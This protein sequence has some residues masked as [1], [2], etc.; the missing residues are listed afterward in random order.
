MAILPGGIAS[1]EAFGSVAVSRYIISDGIASSEAFGSSSLASVLSP[2]GVASGSLG[3]PVVQASGTILQTSI[4]Q[5]GIGSPTIV[6]FLTPSAIG[7]GESIGSPVLVPGVAYLTPYSVSV[8][9][10]FG[11]PGISSQTVGSNLMALRDL[12]SAAHY[13][14]SG[15]ND[16]TIS[17]V[18]EDS[19][20]PVTGW[21]ALKAI[22]RGPTR[23]EQAYVSPVHG[24]ILDLVFEVSRQGT[25]TFES[26]DPIRHRV[27]YGTQLYEIVQVSTDDAFSP[28]GSGMDASVAVLMCRRVASDVGDRVGR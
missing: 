19:V 13:H 28:V 17:I 5:G 26:V 18:F 12:L 10:V 8:G 27:I 25:F 21:S 7:S 22:V 20:T 24:I 23:K 3:S 4:S 15:L 2:T 6:L 1:S 11:S 16:K 9:E 14:M